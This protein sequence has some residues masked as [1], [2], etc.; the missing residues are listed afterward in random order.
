MNFKYSTRIIF[1]FDVCLFIFYNRLFSLVEAI[2][3]NNKKVK[4]IFLHE[5]NTFFLLN[6]KLFEIIIFVSYMNRKLNK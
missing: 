1:Y 4:L 5:I 3:K 2:K 6:K